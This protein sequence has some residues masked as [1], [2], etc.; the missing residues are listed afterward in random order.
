MRKGIFFISLLCLLLPLSS[1]TQDISAGHKMFY[2]ERWQSAEKIFEG[3]ANKSPE[4]AY[5]LVET[6]LAKD[7]LEEAKTA[8]EKAA[9]QFPNN[10]FVVVAQGH[11]L[12]FSGKGKLAKEAFERAVS[13]SEKY[14]ISAILNAVGRANGNVPMKYSDPDYGIDKLKQAAVKDPSNGSIYINMGDCYRRKLDGGGAVEAYM[15]AMTIQ[16]ELSTQANYKI[17]K[18]YATQQNCEVL[19]RYFNTAIEKDADFM[20]AWRELYE[21]SIN[22]EINC[23]DVALAGKYFEKY[24]ATSDPGDEKELLQISFA[25]NNRDYLTAI[26]KAKQFISAKGNS[27]PVRIYKLIGYSYYEQKMYSDAARWLEDYFSR[28]TNAENIVTHNY[29]TLAIVYDSAGQLQKAKQAYLTAGEFESDNIKKWLY[30]EQASAIAVRMKD[31]AGAAEILQMIIDKKSNPSK[32]EYFKCGSSWYNAGKYAESIKIFNQYCQKYSEDWR[33]PLWLG[34]SHAQID[35][36]MSTG[37]AGPYYEKALSLADKIVSDKMTGAMQIEAYMY[38]FAWNINYKKDKATA[39]SY[40]DKVL[41]ID[42]NH[43]MAKS[44]KEK[45]SKTP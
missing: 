27:V 21:S 15:K 6:L 16:P 31:K 2:Y 30:Y 18:I 19:K 33:G 11:T 38:L 3:T 37:L 5:W 17:G 9:N 23:T 13:L 29:K 36:L 41:F 24:I 25:Y 42:P 1:F 35:S 10:P 12:L 8:V 20:P 7:N 4:A 40:L 34:R 28:E 26:S 32:T 44:Y 43:V 14:S 39:I 45:F 22:P